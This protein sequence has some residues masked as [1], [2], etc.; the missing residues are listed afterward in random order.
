MAHP[1]ASIGSIGSES[2][3]DD[4]GPPPLNAV[5]GEDVIAEEDAEAHPPKQQ[6][7]LGDGLLQENALTATLTSHSSSAKLFQAA[8][9]GASEELEAFD[10]LLRL[11]EPEIEGAFVWRVGVPYLSSNQQRKHS[12]YLLLVPGLASCNMPKCVW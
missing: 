5:D 4:D 8:A 9:A 7:M 3:F 6:K 1:M 12:C 2:S 11:P 10:E